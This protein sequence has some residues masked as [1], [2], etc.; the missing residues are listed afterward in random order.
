[1]HFLQACF[2][3]RFTVMSVC[4]C[5]CVFVCT[6]FFFIPFPIP[7]YAEIVLNLPQALQQMYQQRVP[8]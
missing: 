8:N 2:H 7:A 3:V 4:V 5:A 1:M 6:D